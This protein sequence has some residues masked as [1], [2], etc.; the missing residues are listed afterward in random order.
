[1]IG[2]DTKMPGNKIQ[3]NWK[4]KIPL[5][6]FQLHR[7]G[8]IHAIL[9]LHEHRDHDLLEAVDKQKGFTISVNHSN[10]KLQ[11]KIKWMTDYGFMFDS[12]LPLLSFQP[13]SQL[14]KKKVLLCK[15]LI[16]Q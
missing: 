6:N 9:N 8:K 3:I 15:I 11:N 1:M 5:H 7:T 2:H 13:T 14:C 12:E 10:S 16:M 4:Q